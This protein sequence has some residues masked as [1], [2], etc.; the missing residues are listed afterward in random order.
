MVIAA[1]LLC[2][3][4]PLVPL[5]VQPAGVTWPTQQWPAGS[6]P[7]G[8][9]AAALAEL[10]DAVNRLD[11][12]LGQTRAVV[13]V[14]HGR[15][16]AERYRQGFG[17]ATR[18]ISWSM[19]KSITQA[20]VGIA[21]RQGKL[22]P[23]RPMG[24]PRW[25]SGDARAAIP[26]RQWLQMVDGQA[27]REIGVSNPAESDAAK[28]LFGQGRLDA[29]GYAAHLPLIHRPGEHWNYNSA[30][31]ILT[32]DA[33]A[34]AVAPEAASPAARRSAM[35]AFM[36]R[37][38]FD[39]IGMTSAQPE[40]DASGTFLGSALFYATAQ[41][42]ARFGLLYLRDGVWEGSR[43]LPEGWVDFARTAAPGSDA[44]IYGAGF[45][46]AP[47]DG[48]PRP[49]YGSAILGPRDAFQ[50]QGFE[51]QLTVIVPSKDLV[52]VRLGHMPERGWRA[53]SRWVA[54]VVSLFPDR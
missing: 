11:E 42:F 47:A 30:G 23:D 32:D 46:V 35:R 18:L 16:V 44:N 50:A 43:V 6:F 37:E 4:A 7:A 45:W 33:L 17:P 14:H 28:M 48:Q 3:A 12:L 26:W 9:D 25:A 51:G 49:P 40:F 1:L 15:L 36:Q 53:L 24:N 38:L 8:V 19:A 2:L 39:R 21:V 10:L 22:D 34:R 5:P 52:L 27:Y 41:D 13:L 54:N 20:M 29:A 31:I